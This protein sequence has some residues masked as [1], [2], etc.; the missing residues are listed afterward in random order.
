[1]FHA[2]PPS[3]RH[4]QVSD[5]AR[6]RTAPRTWSPSSAGFRMWDGDCAAGLRGLERSKRHGERSDPV[7]PGRQRLTFA[8]HGAVE[9]SDGLQV[10]ACA[11]QSRSPRPRCR[12]ATARRLRG[13]AVTRCARS[14]IR[15]SRAP[16]SRARVRNG[17]GVVK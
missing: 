7:P 4:R 10:R 8:A 13:R 3:R 1:V 15:W 11:R 2:K 16:R 6:A 9:S 14:A 17:E 5:R 12:D